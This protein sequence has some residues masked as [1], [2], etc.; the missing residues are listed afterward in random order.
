[1]CAELCGFW[2]ALRWALQLPP[3]GPGEV[4]FHPDCKGTIDYVNGD[5]QWKD[6]ARAMSLCHAL[7]RTLEVKTRTSVSHCA[8]HDGHPWNELADV[9]AGAG[10]RGVLAFSPKGS[11]P[12]GFLSNKAMQDWMWFARC[13]DHQR[14]RSGLPELREDTM[15]CAKPDMTLNGP[16]V[17]CDLGISHDSGFGESGAGSF[18]LRLASFNV[19]TLGEGSSTVLGRTQLIRDQLDAKGFHITGIQEARS[20][21]AGLIAS[22]AC[23][24]PLWKAAAR[25]L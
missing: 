11:L 19:R 1:M 4:H 17:K 7:Y 23:G 8:A 18:Q 21:E 5:A 22:Q 16:S 12:P 24:W 14:A 6:P 9:L 10:S 3:A 2:N 20:R 15:W 25:R 13:S